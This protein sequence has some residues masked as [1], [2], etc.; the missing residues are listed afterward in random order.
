MRIP[1]II[2]II[3]LLTSQLALQGQ[4]VVSDPTFRTIYGTSVTVENDRSAAGTNYIQE[5]VMLDSAGT[6]ARTTTVWYDGLGRPVMTVREGASP[7]GG[8]LAE[9]V[10]YDTRGRVSRSGITVNLSHGG[11]TLLDEADFTDEI[12][13][14]SCRE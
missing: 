10:S 2:I 4:A 9:I 8:D 12:G 11:Y 13:R 3:L 6:S 1:R 14:A 7:T 5:S